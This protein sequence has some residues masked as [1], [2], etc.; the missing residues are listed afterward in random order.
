LL[1]VIWAQDELSFDRFH[2]D[3]DEIYRVMQHV[4]FGGKVKTHSSVPKSLDDVLVDKYPEITHSKPTKVRSEPSNVP[5]GLYSLR[6]QRDGCR[7]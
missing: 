1:I 4:N 2:A 3:K 5:F 7:Q 6:R